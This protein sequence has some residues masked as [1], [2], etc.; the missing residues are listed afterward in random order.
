M[1]KN[2]ENNEIK[3][4]NLRKKISSRDK[5]ILKKIGDFVRGEFSKNFLPCMKKSPKMKKIAGC[6]LDHVV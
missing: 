6:N 2:V 4:F 1:P 3:R 5:K